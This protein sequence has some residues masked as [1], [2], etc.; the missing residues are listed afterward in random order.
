M[1]T[2]KLTS[3]WPSQATTTSSTLLPTAAA[4]DLKKTPTFLRPSHPFAA[5]G[6]KEVAAPS[7]DA[8]S[9]AN[10][11]LDLSEMAAPCS[12]LG[13]GLLARPS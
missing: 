11:Q 8:L 2:V 6:T 7:K 5:R 12:Q 13:A 9:A 4:L 3:I 10:Y 1:E